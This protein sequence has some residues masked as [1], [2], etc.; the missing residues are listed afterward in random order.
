MNKLHSLGADVFPVALVER[1]RQQTFCF[2]PSADARASMASDVAAWA[3]DWPTFS[4]SWSRLEVDT[5]MGDGGRYRK[6]RYAVMSADG[7]GNLQMEPHQPHYQSLEYNRLNGGVARHF[8]PIED[9]VMA[10][11]CMQATVAFGHGFFTA[12]YP[13]APAHIEIH[14]FRIE[15]RPD[16]AGLPTPEGIHR[17]GVDFVLVMMVRRENVE[18]GTTEVFDLSGTR[19]AHFTLTDP[20]D[21]ALVDDQ[22]ALHGVTPVIPRVAGQPAWR[23]V[24][25]ITYR[26]RLPLGSD[27]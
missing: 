5:Y 13:A 16:R 17:D 18:S 7:A 10:S 23:D 6:R 1:L 19:L 26:R 12:L 27:A 3:A 14:Q 22:R 20:C 21:L 11:P 25:V 8:E 24:L 4:D 2:V 15:A 9:R